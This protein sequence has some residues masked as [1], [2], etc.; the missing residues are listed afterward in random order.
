MR[1]AP[2]TDG[3]L[4]EARQ[5]F[6][7]G[8]AAL[9]NWLARQSNQYRKNDL[10]QTYLLIDDEAGR[11]AGFYALA[12]ASIPPDG[13]PE[14]I[15]GPRARHH[16]LTAVLLGQL[17]VDERYAGQG[18]ASDLLIDAMTRT[19]GLSRQIG[20]TALIV[21]ALH[22]KAARFYEYHG[23]RRFPDHPLT[24]MRSMQSIR[25]FLAR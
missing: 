2:L 16:P 13:W 22:D 15:R 18:Y 6:R 17:A 25:R 19:A 5:R 3:L 23:F 20:I 24:L 21:D 11:V 4:K 9:D 10:A 1:I 12:S 7:C 8:E 14:D